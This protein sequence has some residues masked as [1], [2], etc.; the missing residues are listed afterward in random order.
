MG[1]E[2]AERGSLHSLLLLVRHFKFLV[3]DS[4]G[5]QKNRD[6]QVRRQN[7]IDNLAPPHIPDISTQIPHGHPVGKVG[8]QPEQQQFPESALHKSESKQRKEDGRQNEDRPAQKGPPVQIRIQI[9]QTGSQRKV[10]CKDRI[11]I[12]DALYHAS[13]PPYSL[14][15]HTRHCGSRKPCGKHFR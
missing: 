12:L 1:N 15:D 2:M 9:G 5:F 7:R 14:T 10:F 3:M 6:D 8:R 11:C 4:N 13:C